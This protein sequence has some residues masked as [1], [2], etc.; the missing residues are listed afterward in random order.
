MIDLIRKNDSGVAMVEFSIVAFLFILIIGF[1]LDV[2][3]IY[4][5][6]QVLIN[7]STRAARAFAINYPSPGAYSSLPEEN[8]QIAVTNK[9]RSYISS[10][11]FLNPDSVN[12]VVDAVP[13]P[14]SGL[15]SLQVGLSWPGSCIFCFF[16]GFYPQAQG[17]AV[18]EDECFPGC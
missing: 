17:E 7:T 11:F 2:L 15:C 8:L 3:L 6:N 14:N 18:I 1:L 5:K 9:V 12:V 13:V 10:N 16:T 4:F